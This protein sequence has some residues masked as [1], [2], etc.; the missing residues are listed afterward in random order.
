VV[1]GARFG[2]AHNGLME[3]YLQ[4]VSAVVLAVLLPLLFILL[5]DVYSGGLNQM[6]LLSLLDNFAARMLHT[7][8]LLAL[9]TH[10]YLGIKVIV[11]D[12]VHH[13][14][15]RIPLMAVLLMTFAGF[16]IWWL[17]IIWAWAG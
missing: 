12:Y 7:L 11:E 1:S 10:G 13:A 5:M 4:R 16:G 3:W 2:T 9:L 15:L 17:S 6:R 14:G 8:L